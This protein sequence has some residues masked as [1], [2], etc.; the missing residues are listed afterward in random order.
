MTLQAFND[1]Y[2]DLSENTYLYIFFLPLFSLK[3]PTMTTYLTKSSSE[4]AQNL[5]SLNV[6]R[7]QN[8]KKSGGDKAVDKLQRILRTTE[9]CRKHRIL[10]G[11]FSRWY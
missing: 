9:A 6:V 10:K 2:I 5:H 4:K 1:F 8:I 7:L 11:V 3:S